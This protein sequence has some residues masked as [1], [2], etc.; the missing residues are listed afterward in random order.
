[1]ASVTTAPSPDGTTTWR[2]TV[3]TPGAR[4]TQLNRCPSSSSVTVQT[5]SRSRGCL[6]LAFDPMTSGPSS[7][8]C[9]EVMLAV[10]SGQRATSAS[11]SKTTRGGAAMVTVDCSN[12]Y[13]TVHPQTG[14]LRRGMGCPLLGCRN[15]PGPDVLTPS[16]DPEQLR[17]HLPRGPERLRSHCDAQLIIYF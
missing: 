16:D 7:R 1:M 17:Q 5:V 11:T 12:M 6:T 13:Q 14:E 15:A 8:R 3:V 9:T 2:P 4:E 10:H